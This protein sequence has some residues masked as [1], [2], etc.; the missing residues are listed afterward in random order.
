METLYLEWLINKYVTEETQI[1]CCGSCI[2]GCTNSAI[3]FVCCGYT[4]NTLVE[5]L[6]LKGKDN[7]WEEFEKAHP[8]LF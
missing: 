1:R 4:L 2:G 8:E 7:I 6:K 3:C 5:Y